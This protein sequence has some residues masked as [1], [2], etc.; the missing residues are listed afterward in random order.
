MQP[1]R[2]SFGRS[3]PRDTSAVRMFF[4][5]ALI[6]GLIF[7]VDH[8]SNGMVRT[9]LREAGG[10]ASAAV[11]SVAQTLPRTHGFA[12]RAS[13]IAENQE[14]QDALA[15]R[16]EEDAR[17][18][19]L[20]AENETL[21][22][23]ARIATEEN[24]GLSAPVLSSFSTS[25]YGTFVIGAGVRH[26]VREGA[27][28]LTPGGFVLGSIV[29]VQDRTATVEAL[30]APGKNTEATIGDVPLLL[31]GKGGG[32]ARGEAPRDA[33]LRAGDVVT[34]PSFAGRPAGVVV[35]LDSASSSATATLFIRTPTNLDT[36]RFVYVIQ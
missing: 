4:V 5:L 34:I 24:G 27:T 21:R 12:T 26:G 10:L 29:A 35:E 16:A 14:L 28:V 6:V 9:S 23:L 7:G 20:R 18:S 13:L 3:A 17:F 32:N 19:A 11:A 36:L 8:V 15:R 31:R 1:H 25:P 2:P 22:E 30:F 33:A